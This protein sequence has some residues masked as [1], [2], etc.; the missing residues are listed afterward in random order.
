MKKL[1][2]IVGG[3]ISLLIIGVGI[4][5]FLFPQK[6]VD[7]TNSQNANSANLKSKTIIVDG[8]K[9]HYYTNVIV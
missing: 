3:I 2:K 8:Y 5:Y 6:L 1:L 4:I 7:F 9:T